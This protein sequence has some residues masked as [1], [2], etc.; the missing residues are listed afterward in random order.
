MLGDS[1]R[2]RRRQM[3]LAHNIHKGSRKSV[4]PWMKKPHKFNP[5]I[6]C[7]G[8]NESSYFSDGWWCIHEYV[9]TYTTICWCAL[10]LLDIETLWSQFWDEYLRKS[11]DSL[12]Y[13]VSLKRPC[14]S[15]MSPRKMLDVWP[16]SRP[17]FFIHT[18]FSFSEYNKMQAIVFQSYL[19]FRM[20]SEQLYSHM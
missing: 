18:F 7:H 20:V 16:E 8:E 2:Y 6:R 5:S 19:A 12:V 10:L 3:I 9:F 4:C 14:L 15:K 13:L 17:A 1:I 11:Y